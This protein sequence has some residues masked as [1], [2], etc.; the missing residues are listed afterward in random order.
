[1]THPSGATG[2]LDTRISLR[3]LEIFCLIVELG[4]VTRA[5]EHLIVAQPAVSNQ[6][7]N[8]ESWLGIELFVREGSRMVL[9]EAGHRAYTWARETLAKAVEIQRDV[10]GLRVGS[11]GSASIASSMAVGTYLLSPLVADLR[12]RLDRA[13]LTVHILPPQD[14]VRAV[15]T[16]AADFAM[17]SSHRGS[18][19]AGMIEEHL[20]DVPFVLCA[21]RTGPPAASRIKP[22]QLRELPHVAAP[23]DGNYQR[24]IEM[25]MRQLDIEHG[26]IVIRLGHAEAMKRAVAAHDWVVWLPNYTVSEEIEAGALRAIEVEGKQLTER[27]SL[28]YR[29]DKRLSPL[30]L[31]IIDAIREQPHVTLRASRRRGASRAEAAPASGAQTV[32]AR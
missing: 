5:A 4:G 27:I 21:S 25:Q 8:L 18:I 1:M 14:A 28:I 29:R 2:E 20:Y 24:L 31:A 32:R 15:E 26:P 9:T 13:D 17:M 16:G 19:T 30:H 23:T 11:A 6:L 3:R 10:A 7:R 22:D 12:T